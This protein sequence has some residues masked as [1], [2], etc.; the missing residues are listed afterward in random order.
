MVEMAASRTDHSADAGRGGR[1]A[2]AA[3]SVRTSIAVSLI[4]L[5]LARLMA[6]TASA[7]LVA[8]GPFS[9][10]CIW[11]M[12]VQPKAIPGEYRLAAGLFAKSAAAVNP[13]IY[14]FMSAGFRRDT[15][16]ILHRICQMRGGLERKS[17]RMTWTH[18][19][20][21]SLFSYS[22]NGKKDCEA[23]TLTVVSHC[24]RERDT[25]LSILPDISRMNS[26]QD[27]G[28]SV[29][30]ESFH[31]PAP[32]LNRRYVSMKSNPLATPPVVA[33]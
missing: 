29:Q 2:S 12:V 9:V 6:V 27:S 3:S 1:L 33:I 20:Q 21:N 7:Y 5:K 13:F 17:S 28:K 14:F 19:G 11:E 31:S 16:N 22:S 25:F 10:L 26:D 4:D 8:W 18:G 32:R 24:L 23:N 30:F 15:C